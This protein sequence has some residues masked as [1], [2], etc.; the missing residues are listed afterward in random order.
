MYFLDGSTPSD[1]IIDK[2]LDIV[3][4]QPAGQAIGVHCKAGLGRTGSLLGCYF[5]KHYGY[6]AAEFIGW[7]RVCRPGSVIGPQQHFLREMQPIMW[8][9][10]K[11]WRAERG[12][13][14]VD[15]FLRKEAELGRT[16]GVIGISNGMKSVSLGGDG[17][18]GGGGGDA[19][20][21]G[22]YGK[23]ASPAAYGKAFGQDEGQKGGTQAD[24]LRTAKSPKSKG[25]GSAGYGF[26]ASK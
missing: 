2:F 23:A 13:R 22:K 7:V 6:T 4:S 26:A 9:E 1:R 20:A 18:G 25:G 19:A 10:G 14:S 24:F 12:L 8:K 5:M 16:G 11:A 17:G 15:E 3:E 21:S